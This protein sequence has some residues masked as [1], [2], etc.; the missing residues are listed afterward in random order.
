MPQAHYIQSGTPFVNPPQDIIRACPKIR[1]LT[2]Q[3]RLQV[4]IAKQ[5]G[6]PPT[7][8]LCHESAEDLYHF[9][10]DCKTLCSQRSDF[11]D[12]VKPIVSGHEQCTVIFTSR[13]LMLQLIMDCTMPI[14]L[15]PMELHDQLEFLTRRYT[16]AL[17]TRDPYYYWDAE[18][19]LSQGLWGS[20]DRGG[21]YKNKN[22]QRTREYG[23]KPIPEFAD[24]NEP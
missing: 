12:K 10:L 19:I 1:L 17:H 8:L 23:R 21:I 24:K 20:P 9:L 16:Y 15:I 18:P 2:G 22:K 5:S 7:C 13:N 6:G 4:D 14:L 3:Y 11:L